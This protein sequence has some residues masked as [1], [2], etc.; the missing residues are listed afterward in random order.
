M[1]YNLV[2]PNGDILRDIP[3]DVPK[4][5][6][7]ARV[8]KK[9][10]DLQEETSLFSRQG[11]RALGESVTSGVDAMILGAKKGAH[12][13]I[14]DAQ[15]ADLARMT[16]GT[17]E[18]QQQL[19]KITAQEQ[20][21]HEYAAATSDLQ[22]T[23]Q[24]AAPNPSLPLEAAMGVA[25]SIA[26]MTP[27][28]VARNPLP[29]A[30]QGVEMFRSLQYGQAKDLGA[31]PGEAAAFSNITGPSEA[32]TEWIPLGKFFNE[33]GTD[34]IKQMLSKMF[35]RELATEEV[36]TII[37]KGTEQAVVTP[38]KPVD[39]FLRELGH[40]VAVTGL[41]TGMQV[42]VTAPVFVGLRPEITPDNR[43]EIPPTVEAPPV[44]YLPY[45]DEDLKDLNPMTLAKMEVEAN[46]YDEE[47]GKFVKQKVP[48]NQALDTSRSDVEAWQRLLDCLRS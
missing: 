35:M 28:L 46:I 23:L 19:E 30:Q 15:K 8:L 11:M 12:Q 39:Q 3:D 29:L 33:L 9:Y 41:S 31:A 26:A 6:V 47:A 38:N 22:K 14:L 44:E 16:P 32:I 13:E 7:K 10:P 42:G 4:E 34:S 20:T 1:P 17:P 21:T 43:R 2:L 24:E 27:S 45:S 5:E 37:Q 40:D 36:N 48:A 18:Y 25:P